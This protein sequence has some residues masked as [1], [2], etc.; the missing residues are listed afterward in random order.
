[1]STILDYYKY[2][3]LATAAYVRMG[4]ELFIHEIGVGPPQLND[5]HEYSHGISA[6]E[7]LRSPILVPK[8]AL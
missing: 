4:T 7:R 6:S 8:S 3:T 2:A 5:A 1:M